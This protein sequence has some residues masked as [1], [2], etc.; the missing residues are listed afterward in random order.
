MV[1]GCLGVETRGERFFAL[2]HFFCDR[3]STLCP[4][5][6]YVDLRKEI[7]VISMDLILSRHDGSFENGVWPSGSAARRGRARRRLEAARGSGG[8]LRGR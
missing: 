4:Y 6:R 8:Q 1:V 7:Q 2:S 5:M 3:C